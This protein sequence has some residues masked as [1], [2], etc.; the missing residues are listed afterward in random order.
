MDI[1]VTGSVAY[2]YL[3]TFPG[4]FKDHIL[5]E[6]LEKISLSFLVDSMVRRRGGIAA[7]IA[8]TL[9]LLG[10]NPRMMATVGVDFEEFRALLEAKGVN[11]SLSPVIADTY[12]ASFFATT[13]Q[14]NAQMAS[15]Y[16]GAMAHAREVSLR[17]L[18]GPRPDLVVISPNDPSAMDQYID[19]C[20]DLGIKYVYDPSQQI[21]RMEDDGL[22]HGVENAHALFVNEYEYELTKKMTG[23][24]N[25]D[26]LEHLEFYVV[27]LGAEGAVVYT[28]DGETRVQ[29]APPERVLDPTGG[30]DAFRGGFLTGYSRGWD[31]RTCA[32]MG[33]LAAT[34]VLESEGPQEHNFTPQEFA[35]RYRVH[36]EDDGL[37]DELIK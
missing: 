16:P 6:K 13:D 7:N 37:L 15:F 29:A 11:T 19:E 1:I 28:A 32:Q 12:T 3:M 24:S 22:R 27:T 26:L 5:P 2:D 33:G 36:Y 18:D 10:G 17:D 8:Y 4:E 9:A 23:M 35:D 14:S 30:G 34:Y 21:I 20:K 25:K 31:F